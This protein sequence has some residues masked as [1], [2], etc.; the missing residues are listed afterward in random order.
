[1][2]LSHSFTRSASGFHWSVTY[3]NKWLLPSRKNAWAKKR[4][5]PFNL[6]Y[7]TDALFYE[8]LERPENALRLI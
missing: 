8:Y 6:A 7:Q 2:S 3:L 5:T 4:A 1:M